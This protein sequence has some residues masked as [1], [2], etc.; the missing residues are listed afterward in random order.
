MQCEEEEKAKCFF[1]EKISPEND[2]HFFKERKI[3]LGSVLLF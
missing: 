2:S 1:S 3:L